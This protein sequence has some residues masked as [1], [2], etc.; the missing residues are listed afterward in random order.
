MA[1]DF[2]ANQQVIDGATG[3]VTHV[4]STGILRTGSESIAYT[5]TAD[6]FELL[7]QIESD[8]TDEAN[9]GNADWHHA[10]SRH[11][12]DLER[13]QDHLLDIVGDQAVSLENLDAL[14]FRIG[15]LKLEQQRMAQAIE[16]ADITESV[17]LLQ[18]EQRFLEYTLASTSRLFD[19]SLVDFL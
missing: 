12:H 15:D 11:L 8:L 18:Q 1:I 13:T 5:G 6:V 3:E 10:M 14:E 7:R 19:I 2:S 9:V 17:V 16:S 4:D